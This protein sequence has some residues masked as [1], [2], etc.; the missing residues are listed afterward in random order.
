MAHPSAAAVL[1]GALLFALA[2]HAAG[3]YVPGSYPQEYTEGDPIQVY[4]NSLK[5]FDTEMPFEY[6]SMP[7][8]KPPEGV[9]GIANMA[10]PGTLLEGLRIENSPY[11]LSIKVKQ[12]SQVVCKDGPGYYPSLSRKEAATIQKLI[13]EHYR[14]NMILDNLPVTMYDLLDETQEYVRPGFELGYKDEDTGKYYINNHLV[15][16]VLYTVTHGEYTQAKEMAQAADAMQFTARK[17]MGHLPGRVLKA[18]DEADT[19]YMIVGF[20]VSPC[21]IRRTPG[22][23][24]EDV[25]CGVDDFH[26]RPQEVKENEEITYSYDVYWQKSNIKWAS[27]WDAYLRMPGG[28]V[29][30]FSIVNS[31]VVVLVMATLVAIILIR[32]VRQDLSKYEQLV[33]DSSA[34]DLKD[35]AGWKMVAGDVFRSPASSRWLAV[36]VGSGVQIVLTSTISMVLATMGFLSPAARGALITTT[37]VVYVWLAFVAGFVAVYVWGLME[38]TYNGWPIVCFSV[39]LYFPG[40]VLALFTVMNLVIFHTG[41]TGAIPIAM[42][43]TVVLVWFV[44]SIPL[45]FVGGYLALRMPIKEHPVKTNQIPR[46]VPPTSVSSSPWVLFFVAGLLPFG[47][48]FIELY[49]AM[50]SIWLGYFY[51]LFGFLLL[52]GILAVIITVEISVMCTYVQLC[53]ED[54]N[55]WWPSF[56]RGGSIAVYIAIYAIGFLLSRVRY[57]NGFMPIFIYFSYMT[58]VILG[59]YFAMGAVGFIA[60]YLFTYAIFKAVKLD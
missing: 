26:I 39:S 4:V 33:M 54:Y 17:L 8:C 2:S 11:N 55:W 40:I 47:T 30:W 37:M 41:T 24:L 52:I 36:Q 20:E 13:D 1:F 15:F 59:I 32:T 22:L 56:R 60:S 38:R 50:T 51:Y 16:N 28:N 44:V 46:H 25:V 3:F 45:A 43:F 5:S 58:I 10:N 29:H 48:T 34:A 19:Y 9:K 14:V 23:P 31:C 6:Y 27:R 12:T 7:F 42:F 35:D 18:A 53:A 21:S 57:M 49:F